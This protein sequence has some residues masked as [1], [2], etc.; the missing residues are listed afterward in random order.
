M[1]GPR[2]AVGKNSKLYT[3]SL[4]NATES[5]DYGRTTVY[6]TNRRGIGASEVLVRAVTTS[7]YTIIESIA[8]ESDFRTL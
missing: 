4:D 3:L 7:F 8:C 6:Y 1:K 5:S 2:P